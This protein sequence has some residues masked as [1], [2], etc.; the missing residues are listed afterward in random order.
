MLLQVVLVLR[1][2]DALHS[3]GRVLL[4]VVPALPS[5]GGGHAAIQVL[6]TMACACLCSIGSSLQCGWLV[7][8]QPDMSGTRCLYRLRTSVRSFPL[9]GAFPTAEYSA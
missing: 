3:A 5:T 8:L 6:N 7:V 1:R 9:S 2:R 4:Q